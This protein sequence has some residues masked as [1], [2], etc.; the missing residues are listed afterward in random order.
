M[1]QIGPGEAAID[2]KDKKY[3]TFWE[4]RSIHPRDSE[5]PELV[6]KY[7]A[8]GAIEG[9]EY[10]AQDTTI[11]RTGGVEY[12]IR[13]FFAVRRLTSTGPEVYA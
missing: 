9:I 11:Q 5:I 4:S 13:A 1:I 6:E 7:R 10:V 2:W 8:A 3:F 12:P